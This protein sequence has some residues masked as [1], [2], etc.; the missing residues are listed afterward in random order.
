M[1]R[2][3]RM[4]REGW[5][6]AAV[7]TKDRLDEIVQ[8]YKEIGFDVKV[9]HFLPE[10]DGVDGCGCADCPGRF[11]CGFFVVYTRRAS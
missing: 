2:V 6:R 8:L 7:L 4:R 9:F 10:E 1:R 5:E 11:G 3:E